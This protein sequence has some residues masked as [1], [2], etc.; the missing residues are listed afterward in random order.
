MGGTVLNRCLGREGQLRHS[1]PD[2][3]KLEDFDFPNLFKASIGA[4]GSQCFPNFL[5]GIFF[6]FGF[7]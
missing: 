2:P 6:F 4:H 1:N 5:L 7:L 3:V